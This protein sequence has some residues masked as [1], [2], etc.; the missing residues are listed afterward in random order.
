MLLFC[1]VEDTGQT[2]HGSEEQTNGQT[3]QNYEFQ[4]NRQTDQSYDISKVTNR[5]RELEGKSTI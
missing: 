4:T 3:D 2:V 1:C 5:N